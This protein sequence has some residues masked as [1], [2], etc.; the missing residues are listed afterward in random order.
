MLQSMGSQKAG[1]D[2]V[3]KQQQSFLL[4]YLLTFSSLLYKRNWH[5]NPDRMVLWEGSPPSWSAAFLNK[6]VFPCPNTLSLS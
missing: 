5:Q 3:T 4:L 1:H 2:L 6:V